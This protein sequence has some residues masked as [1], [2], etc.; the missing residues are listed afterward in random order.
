MSNN[1]TRSPQLGAALAL[2]QLLQ[3]HPEL[4][5]ASWSV[6]PMLGSLSG[7]LFEESVSAVEAYAEVLGGE[8]QQGLPYVFEERTVYPY[9]LS[10]VWRDVRV[11]VTTTVP[12]AKL[13]GRAA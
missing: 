5:V 11:S 4:E 10:V 9:R 6:D 3:E 13:L 7:F 1:P 12:L 2:A 8:V